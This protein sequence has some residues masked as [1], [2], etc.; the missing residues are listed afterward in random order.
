MYSTVFLLVDERVCTKLFP[1]AA[2]QQL[3]D[4]FQKALLKLQ[5]FTM[6]SDGIEM[7]ERYAEDEV[8]SAFTGLCQARIGLQRS[9]AM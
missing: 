5:F 1:V 7:E 6:G 9:P 8:K 2:E 4:I 3:H